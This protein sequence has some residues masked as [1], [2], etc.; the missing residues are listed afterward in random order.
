MPLAMRSLL[1]RGDRLVY[2]PTGKPTYLYLPSQLI[3]KGNINLSAAKCG[4]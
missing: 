4:T 3:A 2:K 1:A